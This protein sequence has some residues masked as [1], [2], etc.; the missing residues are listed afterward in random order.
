M[1]V[2]RARNVVGAL[3]LWYAAAAPLRAQSSPAPGDSVARRMHVNATSLR[4][5]Q[6][7]YQTTLERDV[8]T[9]I[10]GTRTVTVTQGAYAGMPAWLLIETRSGDGIPAVD[11]LFAD[12]TALRPVHWSS[13]LGGAR[14]VAEFRGDTVYGGTSAPTG[15]HSMV[16]AVPEGSLVSAAMLETA[17][18]LLS[19]QTAWEDSTTILSASLS[20]MTP[21]PARIAVIGQEVVRVPAGSFDC[22]VVS[23]HADQSRGLYWVTKRDPIVVRSMLDV[24]LLGGAELVSALTRIG[25]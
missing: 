14:L 15:R 25:R 13:T 16:A 21:L 4:P 11:S 3:L 20:G 23:V 1:S 8:S 24:P 9:T 17:I 2:V 10:L 19:L 22:W 12:L 18:R 6:Y 7:V 5:G